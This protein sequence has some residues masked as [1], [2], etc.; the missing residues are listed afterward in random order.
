MEIFER[1]KSTQKFIVVL[2]TYAKNKAKV[3][4]SIKNN[5]IF[6][7]FYRGVMSYRFIQPFIC[8]DSLGF[9]IFYQLK[10]IKRRL[11]DLLGHASKLHCLPH[12]WHHPVLSPSGNP[13]IL[14]I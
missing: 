2:V 11:F 4:E 14:P 8:N 7:L 6:V 10:L 1:F 5:P 13:A 9:V 3:I 12:K